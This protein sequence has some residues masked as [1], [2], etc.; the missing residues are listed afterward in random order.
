M[1][2]TP[3]PLWQHPGLDVHDIDVADAFAVISAAFVKSTRGL[4][5]PQLPWDLRS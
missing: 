3:Q 2:L 1:T 4:N 5:R